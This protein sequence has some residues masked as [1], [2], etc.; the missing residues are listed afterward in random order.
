[1][2]N[3]NLLQ[4]WAG[5]APGDL[6]AMIADITEGMGP[7]PG[8]GSDVLLRREFADLKRTRLQWRA[9]AGGTER[10][11]ATLEDA[12]RALWE[13]AASV[14]ESWDITDGRGSP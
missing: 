11:G 10:T 12:V 6:A 5:D 2:T 14:T 9:T 8:I 7:Y 13:H 4:P 1:M 3:E